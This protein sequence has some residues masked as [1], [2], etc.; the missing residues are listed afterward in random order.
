MQSKKK[1]V[2]FIDWFYPGYKAGGPVRSCLNMIEALKDD[3]DFWVI[4]RDTD[5]CTDTPYEQV[6][7]DT[8]NQLE[9]HLH[10]Y[11][12]SKKRLSSKGLQKVVKDID[13]DIA[14]INGIYSF[15]FSVLPVWLLRR[16]PQRKIVSVRGMLA[17]TAVEV[18]SLKKKLFLK[19]VRLINLYKNIIFHT[20]N[21]HEAKQV[22]KYLSD[23]NEVFVADNLPNLSR[24]LK[25]EKRKK[26]VGKLKLVSL[27]RISEEKNIAFAL[28][29]LKEIEG[30]EVQFDLY[31][32]VYDERYWDKCQKII[33]ELPG[34]VAVHYKGSLPAE[35][36]H[37]SFLT[38]HL[39]LMP[40][41]GENFGHAIIEALQ[42]SM[43]VLISDRTP[44]NN[45]EEKKCGKVISLKNPGAFSKAV[46]EYAN[47][48]QKLYDEHSQAAF[49]FAKDFLENDS[50]IKDYYRLFEHDK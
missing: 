31:G 11:Y 46:I 9:E 45:I 38:Y 1:I 33:A 13:F 10:V 22:G 41:R 32:Q 12:F 8:W 39:L 24:Q 20:T 25:L 14:Y 4:T 23:T 29:I 40:S 26:E 37:D 34:N 18:K 5:Y 47:M 3:Y 50:R 44:W 2:I 42:S 7:S 48:N 36:V 35:Y 15:Y 6:E 28:E 49:E 43:P 21:T 27:A 19:L 30:V 17:D 16:S